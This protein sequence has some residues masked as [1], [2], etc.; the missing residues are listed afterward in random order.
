LQPQPGSPDIRSIGEQVSWQSGGGQGRN[1]RKIILD[2]VK[3][4]PGR[5]T[6]ELRQQVELQ[7]GIGSGS[8]QAAPQ[9]NDGLPLL[10][11]IQGCCPG[12]GKTHLDE[13]QQAAVEFLFQLLLLLT[14]GD[15]FQPGFTDLAA[16]TQA[17]A[18]DI[19]PAAFALRTA[20]SALALTRPQSSSS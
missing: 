8:D 19:F 12:Q 13:F 6:G 11:D 18:V 10:V 5:T 3:L 7:S 14:L 17:Q 15:E 1:F 2:K 4:F 9:G 20:P 16:Q